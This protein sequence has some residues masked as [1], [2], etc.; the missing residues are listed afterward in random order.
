[1]RI[2]AAGEDPGGIE[3]GGRRG[4]AGAPVRIGATG[5][6]PRVRSAVKQ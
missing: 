4:A 2:G 1:M 3:G 6:D 5:E